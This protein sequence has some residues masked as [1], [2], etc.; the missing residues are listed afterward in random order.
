M[1]RAQIMDRI[2]QLDREINQT[3][4]S[5]KLPN[6]KGRRFPLASWI[7]AVLCLGAWVVIPAIADNGVPI[8]D[9]SKWIALGLGVIIGLGAI[10]RT[11]TWIVKMGGQKTDRQYAQ[12]MSK[13]A[14]LKKE[15]DNL[16]KQLKGG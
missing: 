5:N 11:F 8:P 14:E 12:N 7:L 1:D 2:A 6:L 4:A 3:I 9:W 13:V 15:R 16:Q 10:Y